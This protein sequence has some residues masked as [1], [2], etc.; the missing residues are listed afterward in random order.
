[1]GRH[2]IWLSF[3]SLCAITAAAQDLENLQVHGFA[4]QG[5]L[6]SSHNNYLTM[7]SSD[8]SLQW[9]EGALSFSQAVTEKLRVGIQL[10]MSQMGEFGGPELE[11]DWASGDYKFNDRLGVR[12]GKIKTPLGLYNDS[13]DV[14]S[15]HLWVL[16][17]QGMYPVDNRDYDL[18]ELGGEVYGSMPLG[19][20]RGEIHYRGHAGGSA[21]AEDGGY[22]RQLQQYGVTF[23][24]PPRGS[25]FGGDVR[26]ATPLAGLTVGSSAISTSLEGTGD[27]GS[28][29]MP[30]AMTLAYYAQFNRGKLHLAGEYWRVPLYI[31]L[32]VGPNN[33]VMP[34][35]SRAW[36][37]MA[38]YDLTK[39]L[40]VGSYYSHYVNKTQSTQEYVSYSKDWVVSGRYN[41][42]SYF[43]GKLEAHFLHGTGLGYYQSTN[44][45]GLKPT[46]NM[47]AARV[48][49]SF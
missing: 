1:M 26:W 8:G 45:D 48:G 42:N 19:E 27:I 46:T 31:V 5:F 23:P 40:Q 29:R 41:F 30:P 13:Q 38:S 34:M 22:V 39:R 47:L 43:Y 14:D 11:V 9:T 44:P 6:Y 10:H 20:R 7:K 37:P 32:N 36:Y 49:F 18:S 16:L 17:P 33:I 21:L 28:L 35:D 25:T 12:M 15:L 4:T 2:S 3:V 24:S